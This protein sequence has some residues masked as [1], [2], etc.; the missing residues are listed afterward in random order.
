VAGK[1]KVI[2]RSGA[3]DTITFTITA[4]E[5]NLSRLASLLLFAERPGDSDLDMNTGLYMLP[6]EDPNDARYVKP[7]KSTE[8]LEKEAA[9][10]V[11][12]IIN[13]WTNGLEDVKLTLAKFGVQRVRELK[14][15]QLE[16]FIKALD[17]SPSLAQKAPET[18]DP[19]ELV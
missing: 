15:E 16:S 6:W 2:L 4:N 19:D 13:T 12:S 7:P 17:L 3:K 1:P 11:T 9:E 14:P 8:E 18:N 5:A 10:K